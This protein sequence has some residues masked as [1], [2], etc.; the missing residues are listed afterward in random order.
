MSFMRSNEGDDAG[1][2]QASARL[3]AALRGLD[4]FSFWVVPTDRPRPGSAIVVGT[5]GP[6]LILPCG[7]AGVLTS[8]RGRARVG[9]GHIPDLR[10]L[11]RGARTLGATMA[12]ASVHRPVEP[13][14]CLTA[15]M[16]ARPTP[17]RGVTVVAAR[18]LVAYIAGRPASV[19]RSRAQ[20]AARSLGMQIAG[21]HKRHFAVG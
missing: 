1:A 5:T 13:V 7:L 20:R 3:A 18:D 21:D 14:V 4:P 10:S 15:A 2:R 6:F 16:V 17:V 11:K 8:A 12:D 9:G 19:P